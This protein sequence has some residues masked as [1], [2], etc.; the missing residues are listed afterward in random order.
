[1]T[2]ADLLQRL[3]VADVSGNSA[4]SSPP[5]V[6]HAVVQGV[7]ACP[8]DLR[9]LGI[10]RADAYLDL[11]HAERPEQGTREWLLRPVAETRLAAICFAM[12]WFE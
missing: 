7:S 11:L 10:E 12:A 3:G 4:S 5:E 1:M 6:S 2:L 8:A 9:A